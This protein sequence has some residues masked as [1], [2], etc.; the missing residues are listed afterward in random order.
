MAKGFGNYKVIFANRTET[1]ADIMGSEPLSPGEMNKKLWAYI[2]ANALS[3]K[4]T[5]AAKPEVA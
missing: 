1:I 4:P 5:P 2:K 3:N